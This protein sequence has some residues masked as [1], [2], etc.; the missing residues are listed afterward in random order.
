MFFCPL[1]INLPPETVLDRP[2]FF[3]R[4]WR[5]ERAPP[6]RYVG[7]NKRGEGKVPGLPSLPRPLELLGL[8]AAHSSS[9]IITSR[10]AAP[11]LPPPSQTGSELVSPSARSSCLSACWIF[12]D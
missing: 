6:P 5:E 12:C 10:L 4:G 11:L 1:I 7:P 9:L 8:A 3:V 2:A